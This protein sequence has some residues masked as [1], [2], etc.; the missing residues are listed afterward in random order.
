M[1]IIITIL[2]IILVWYLA[3]VIIKLAIR[4]YIKKHLK[5]YM[6]NYDI[7]DNDKQGPDIKI[8]SKDSTSTNAQ[9]ADFEE[10]D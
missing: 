7:N 5:D 4:F 10:I 6:D 2:S 8:S 3:G 1:G 9:E